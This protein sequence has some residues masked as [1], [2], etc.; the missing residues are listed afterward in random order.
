MTLEEAA[1]AFSALSPGEQKELIAQLIY[2]LTVVARGGY[3]VGGEGL[4]DPRLVRRIN[5]VQHFLGAFLGKLLREDPQRYPDEV[6]LRIVLE[7]GGDEELER[8]VGAAFA[9]AHRLTAV[10]SLS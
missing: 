9:R 10:V 7:H 4:T 8:Q 2:E 1:A 6:L 5:E 3:E